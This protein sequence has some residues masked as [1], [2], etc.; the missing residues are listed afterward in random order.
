MRD[1]LTYPVQSAVAVAVDW[2]NGNLYWADKTNPFIEIVD[3]NHGLDFPISRQRRR[4]LFT[5]GIID[6]Y[7][8]VIDPSEL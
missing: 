6:I 5:G 4:I 2:L 7:S 1:V 3:L 8:I